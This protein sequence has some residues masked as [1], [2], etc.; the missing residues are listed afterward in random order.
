MRRLAVVVLAALCGLAA[1][2]LVSEATTDT[3]EAS[4]APAPAPAPAPLDIE[5][6]ER[7]G[8]VVVWTPGGLDPAVPAALTDIE[9]VASSVVVRGDLVDMVR[10]E[11]ADG[12]VVDDPPGAAVIPLDALAV[13]P[14]AYAGALSV[15]LAKTVATLAAGEVLLGETSATLRRLGPGD[16]IEL[17]GGQRFHVAAVVPDDV[18][19]GAEVV[20]TLEG[21]AAAGVTTDRYV[22]AVFNGDR[23]SLDAAIHDAV[24][25]PVRIRGP[26]ETPFLRH[27]D[28]VLTQAEIKKRFGEFSYTPTPDGTLRIHSAWEAE[29]LV[30]TTVPLLGQLRC[31][32][33]I[34]GALG[35]AMQSLVDDGLD[36]L[37][38]SDSFGGCWNA[39][40]IGPDDA[41]SRHAWGVAVDLN[42]G[43]NP[44]GVHAAIDHRVVGALEDHGFTWGGRWLVPDPA[45]FEYRHP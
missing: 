15:G 31:H 36:H 4:P 32:R 10:S 22:L 29:H 7:P 5:E 19:A 14:A 41:L 9:P 11:S 13:D 2:G 39:R 30:T 40:R 20:F 26:G 1:G 24:T 37:V 25:T 6:G 45:H 44:T 3:V 33:A 8:V 34:V 35:A 42:V 16:H 43:K 17:A 23:A 18:V 27:G 21:G 38:L 28:A 12:T